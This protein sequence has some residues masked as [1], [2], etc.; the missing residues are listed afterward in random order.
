M[1]LEP[2][3]TH[4]DPGEEVVV[5]GCRERPWLTGWHIC[6]TTIGVAE[7]I[8]ANMSGCVR[9]AGDGLG[10]TRKERPAR[11]PRGRPIGR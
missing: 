1:G 2:I 5:T 10:V 8:E 6:P 9:R 3:D 7:P 11:A 4:D